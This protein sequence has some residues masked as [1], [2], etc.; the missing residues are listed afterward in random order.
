MGLGGSTP[1][2][3]F[4]LNLHLLD[5]YLFRKLD[6]TFSGKTFYDL[7]SEIPALQDFFNTKPQQFYGHGTHFLPER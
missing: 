1:S 2:F 5:Y 7:D 3:Q 6:N 4:Y